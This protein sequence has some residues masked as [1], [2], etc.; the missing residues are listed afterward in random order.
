MWVEY[1]K[2]DLIEIL[3]EIA[4]QSNE[5]K[6]KWPMDGSE[7]SERKRAQQKNVRTYFFVSLALVLFDANA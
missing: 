4:E 5:I 1:N 6:H 3:A 7:K 2:S